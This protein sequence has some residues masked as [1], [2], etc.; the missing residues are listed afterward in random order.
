MPLY[1]MRHGE[2]DWN[3][4]RRIQGGKDIGLNERG[5]RQIQESFRQLH[6]RVNIEHIISSP[7][8]RAYESA[9]LISSIQG[10]SVHVDSRFSERS[11]GELEGMTFEEIRFIYNIENPELIDSPIFGVESMESMKRRI[12]NGI[13]SLGNLTEKNVLLVTHGSVISITTG[14][15]QIP[16]NGSVIE[17]TKQ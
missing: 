6:G 4:Q 10:L 13:R 8:Q 9:N 14:E 15:T 7:L 5:V 16:S 3:K 2:T 17:F 1:L 12:C 11:F